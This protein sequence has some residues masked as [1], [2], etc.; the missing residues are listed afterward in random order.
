MSGTQHERISE[1]CAEL[2]LAA[3]P[4]GAEPARGRWVAAGDFR[5]AALPGLM[6]KVHDL[7]RGALE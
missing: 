6:R 4:K 7:A 5:P 2:R 3:V 1:L